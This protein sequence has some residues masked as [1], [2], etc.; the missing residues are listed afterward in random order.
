[1][2]NPNLIATVDDIELFLGLTSLIGTD[3]K[4]DGQDILD[5]TA[6][7]LIADSI[8]YYGN[9]RFVGNTE[10]GDTVEIVA[11]PLDV[12]Q[13]SMK[14]LEVNIFRNTEEA[15]KSSITND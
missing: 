1:M 8:Y 14:I 15:L 10:L 3:M 11:K 6:G 2:A 5:K 4:N 9:Y 13:T 12:K 7:L